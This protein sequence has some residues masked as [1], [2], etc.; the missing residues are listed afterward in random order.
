MTEAQY[1]AQ[2]KRQGNGCWICK[3]TPEQEGRNLAVDHAHGGSLFVPKGMVRGLL[4]TYCNQKLIGRHKDPLLFARAAK[5]LRRHLP[6]KAPPK[7]RKK[8]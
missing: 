5:Y 1:L 4:C 6:Y 3:K 7:K 2:L 8:K